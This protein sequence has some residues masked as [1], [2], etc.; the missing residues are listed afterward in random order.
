MRSVV[1]FY[2]SNALSEDGPAVLHL[3]GCRSSVHTR[4]AVGEVVEMNDGWR[5]RFNTE[6][7]AQATAEEHS[8]ERNAE[9]SGSREVTTNP[10]CCSH[11][12]S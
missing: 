9:D 5:E 4:I 12:T 6:E 8:Q 11:L 1:R 7:A 10:H 3:V 2:R